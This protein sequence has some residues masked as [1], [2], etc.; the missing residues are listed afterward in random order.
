LDGLAVWGKR[1]G[2]GVFLNEASA[3]ILKEPGDVAKSAGARVTLAHELCHLLLDGRHALTAI[4]V[5]KARMP[6]GV[7]QRAKSF[8]GEL[9]LPRSVAAQHWLDAGRPRDRDGLRVLI[10]ELT[11]D[12]EVTWSVAAWKLDHAARSSGADLSAI[13]DT[14]APYR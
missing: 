12:F 10:K 14:V 1:H 2:P 6:P 13:L 5:L 7:E 3:R 4:E 11:E 9:L 8:A